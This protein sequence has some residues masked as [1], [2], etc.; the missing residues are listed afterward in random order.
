MSVEQS[1]KSKTLKV[2]LS[3][4][5]IGLMLDGAGKRSKAFD[6]QI[7]ELLFPFSHSL[8]IPV[9]INTP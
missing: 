7:A 6:M 3:E 2:I 1:I 5:K 9:A 4:N 8:L